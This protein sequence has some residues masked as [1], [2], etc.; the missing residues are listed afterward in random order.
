MTRY[1][2]YA[3]LVLLALLGG[4]GWALKRSYAANGEQA[5]TITA[6]QDAAEAL[7]EQGRKDRALIDKHAKGKALARAEAEKVRK[8]MEDSL[9]KNQE[10]AQTHIPAEVR[11]ALTR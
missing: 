6:L 1:L 3:I 2:I 9:F 8:A 11:D 10:W 7:A 4:A 5:A